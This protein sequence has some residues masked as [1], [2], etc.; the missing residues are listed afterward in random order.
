MAQSILFFPIP[1]ELLYKQKFES[2]NKNNDTGKMKRVAVNAL[3][4][5]R[6][7]SAW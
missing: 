7:S 6:E 1:R 5:V 4:K 3:E 2:Q